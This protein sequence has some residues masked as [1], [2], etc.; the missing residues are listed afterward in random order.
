LTFYEFLEPSFTEVEWDDITE[1]F[2]AELRHLPD[3]ALVTLPNYSLKQMIGAI[4]VSIHERIS[5]NFNLNVDSS[6][7]G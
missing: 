6:D 1:L 3:G 7:Y 2:R 4:E 5:N